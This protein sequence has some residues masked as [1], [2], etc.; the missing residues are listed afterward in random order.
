MSGFHI[1]IGSYL[2]LTVGGQCHELAASNPG[3]KQLLVG[4]VGFPFATLM[5]TTSGGEIFTGDIFFI[6]S[7]LVE[8]F[9]NV[10]CFIRFL[11]VTFIGNFIGGLT[12]AM[13]AT[14]AA[15]LPAKV[16]IAA[17]V[18][19]T[20]LSFQSAFVRGIL[21][22]TLICMAAYNGNSGQ[23]FA[24]KALGIFFPISAFVSLGLENSVSNM[25]TIPFGIM[26]GAPVSV[27]QY[28]LKNL[29]PVT[30]GNLVGG[31]FAVAV[32]YGFLNGG[33]SGTRNLTNTTVGKL[34]VSK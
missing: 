26:N 18:A 29:L 7:A 34:S 24:D 12:M 6:G 5:T 3:L 27:K 10:R 33:K 16:P 4:A 23:S 13:L 9:V 25:F 30:L 2:S 17:A 8:G 28:L 1:G 19:K 22:S 21:C 32:P 11:A 31:I 15:T 14:V 20:S